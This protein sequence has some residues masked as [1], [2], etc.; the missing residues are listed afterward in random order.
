MATVLSTTGELAKVAGCNLRPHIGDILPLIIDAVGH[1][2]NAGKSVVAVVT[3]GQAS[4]QQHQYLNCQTCSLLFDPTHGSLTGPAELS[5]VS[6]MTLFD[7]THSLLT[8]HA[9][10]SIVSWM[11]LFDPTHASLTGYAELSIVS[12]MSLLS[13]HVPFYHQQQQALERYS[14]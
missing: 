4:S 3:L 1:P 12:C 9:E 7:P 11:S 14:W 13:L 8:G 5:I 6:W 10:L 2:S